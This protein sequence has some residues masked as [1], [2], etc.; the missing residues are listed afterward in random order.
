MD[1]PMELTRLLYPWKSSGK[2]TG[3]G[4]HS[5]LQEIFATEGLNPGLLH[6]RQILYHLSHYGRSTDK[7]HLFHFGSLMRLVQCDWESSWALGRVNRLML[8]LFLMA[9]IKPDL[10]RKWWKASPAWVVKTSGSFSWFQLLFLSVTSESHL[11]KFSQQSSYIICLRF[12][13][14]FFFLWAL[15]IYCT[16]YSFSTDYFSFFPVYNCYSLILRCFEGL[17]HIVLRCS[18]FFQ[19]FHSLFPTS[20]HCMSSFPFPPPCCCC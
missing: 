10:G 7:R 11:Q 12:F 14:D 15:G 19:I 1:N 9:L 5:L 13:Y 2:N 18:V 16:L 4:N 17:F 6:C 20:P 3:T 8:L